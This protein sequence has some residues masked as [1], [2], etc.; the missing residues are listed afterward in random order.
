MTITAT[1]AKANLSKYLMISAVEDVFITKNGTVIS[2]LTR[3]TVDR[4]AALSSLV[5]IIPEEY[6]N[7]DIREERLSE[8]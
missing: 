6:G 4:A 8:K 3:P 2:K 7:T 1:E 5:G